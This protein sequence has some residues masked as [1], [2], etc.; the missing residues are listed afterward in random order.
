MS[1][2]HEMFYTITINQLV[3]VDHPFPLAYI[4]RNPYGPFSMKTGINDITL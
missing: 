1:S 3:N 2:Q 4:S